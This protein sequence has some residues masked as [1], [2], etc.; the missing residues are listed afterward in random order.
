VAPKIRERISLMNKPDTIYCMCF[1]NSF[2]EQPYR[3][4][5]K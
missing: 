2:N 1:D 3:F 5:V 4:F